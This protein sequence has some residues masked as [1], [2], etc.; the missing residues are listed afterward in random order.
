MYKTAALIIF[1]MLLSVT[2]FTQYAPDTTHKPISQ[3]SFDPSCLPAT[4]LNTQMRV[5]AKDFYASHLPF[6][7][8]KEV[9]LEKF[10]KIPFRFRLGSL[11]YC[12]K[13]EGKQQ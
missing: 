1:K 7:C 8:N 2:A 6:F 11:E 5:I 13:M 10:T 4:P 9:Q 12:N 3:L